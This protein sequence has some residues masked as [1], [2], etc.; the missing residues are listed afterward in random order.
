MNSKDHISFSEP[1]Q[2]ILDKGKDLNEFYYLS[3]GGHEN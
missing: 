2:L 3:K 1:R